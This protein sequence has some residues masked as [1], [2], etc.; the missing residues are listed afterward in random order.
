[1]TNA[2]VRR[3]QMRVDPTL[4]LHGFSDSW[5]S[6]RPQLCTTCETCGVV[7]EV[8]PG[9]VR[10]WAKHHPFQYLRGALLRRILRLSERRAKP[11]HS[12]VTEPR[13]DRT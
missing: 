5:L 11:V 3:H 4:R 7:M 12:D 6:E 2:R 13:E 8:G 9:V 1:M 10:H